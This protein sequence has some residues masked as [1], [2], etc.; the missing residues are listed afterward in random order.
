MAI[1]PVQLVVLG[2][3]EPD[4]KGEILAELDRLKESDTVRLI[5]GLAVYKDKQGNVTMLK[6]SD[7]SDEEAQ[8]FGAVVGALIGL[9]AAGEDGLAAGAEVG[10]EVMAEGVDLFS[11][12]EAWDAV[13]DVPNDSAAAFILIEHRW[14]IPFR[15]AVR[16]AGGFAISDGFIHAEDLVAVGLMSAAEAEEAAAA[17]AATN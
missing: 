13:D 17:S 4:F 14:A 7:L 6:R 9:G 12:E 16:R 15:D 3:N 11:E 5:D 8:E 2:F 10:S 1:G